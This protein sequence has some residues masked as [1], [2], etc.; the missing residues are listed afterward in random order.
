[1]FRPRIPL[2]RSSHN[3]LTADATPSECNRSRHSRA[4][5]PPRPVLHALLG[6][7]AVVST[8]ALTEPVRPISERASGGLT[9]A[10]ARAEEQRPADVFAPPTLAV[11]PTN[12][13]ARPAAGATASD[14]TVLDSLS[15]TIGSRPAAETSAA[16]PVGP[17]AA[18]PDR[19]WEGTAARAGYVRRAQDS[20]G[21]PVREL[22]PGEPV[23]VVDWVA[24]EE[25]EK[26]NNTWARLSDGTYV[27]STLLRRAPLAEPPALPA[28]APDSGR[29]IDVNLTEQV[30]VAYEGRTPVRMA[31]VSTGRPG[32][33][34]PTGRFTIGRRMAKDTMDGST[35]V[36]MGPNRTGASYRIE[37]VKY[38]QY[39]TADGA[40]IHENTWRAAGTFGMLGSHGCI[41]MTTADAAFFWDFATHGTPLLI[42]E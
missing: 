30:A 40:A 42:H 15:S 21:K 9:V 39:F 22:T 31:L 28:D 18:P 16:R 26:N 7:L 12:R 8:T 34:T 19:M 1:M 4:G 5:I 3:G 37:D 23:V 14:A 6:L 2:T 29:W 11:A 33:D 27:F 24:G 38:V 25:V 32:W 10:A 17:I 41:G 13:S 35:L 20:G 36:G